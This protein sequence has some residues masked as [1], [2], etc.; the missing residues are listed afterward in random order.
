VGIFAALCDP[1]PE[2]DTKML[3]AYEEDELSSTGWFGRPHD[4]THNSN[5]EPAHGRREQQKRRV[6]PKHH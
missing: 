2:S 1:F 3:E 6:N 5:D 4:A